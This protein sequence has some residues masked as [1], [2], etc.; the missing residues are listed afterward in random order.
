MSLRLKI[1]SRTTL[2]KLFIIQTY[3][4]H[5]EKINLEKVNSMDI[6]HS[7]SYQG[8][9]DKDCCCFC[10]DSYYGYN[11]YRLWVRKNHSSLKDAV[12]FDMRERLIFF[13]DPE[14]AF[15]FSLE[16]GEILEPR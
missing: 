8:S 11:D 3:D 9:K 13:E 15:K 14:D 4:S 12:Y 10:I 1:K 6:F 2:E 5:D 16:F 7:N